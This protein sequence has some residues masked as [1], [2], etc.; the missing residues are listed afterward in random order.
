MMPI[1]TIPPRP[2]VLS[3]SLAVLMGACMS[4]APPPRATDTTAAVEREEAPPPAPTPAPPPASKIGA[5]PLVR[6]AAAD[7][8]CRSMGTAAEPRYAYDSDEF[9]ARSITVGDGGAARSFAP[10]FV[11]IRA[12]QT[13]G[14]GVDDHETLYVMFGAEGQIETGTRQYFNTA[15]PPVRETA[16]LLPGDTAAVRDVA[17]YV[18]QKCKQPAPPAQ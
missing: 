17:L 8:T 5:I 4:D 13:V 7:G 10:S 1:R 11:E 2:R 16:G 12:R 14:G 18:L 9:P 3:L 6:P 15:S